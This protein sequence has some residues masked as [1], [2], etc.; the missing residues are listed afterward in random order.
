MPLGLRTTN[1]Y[2]GEPDRR[3]LVTKHGVDDAL[4]CTLTASNFTGKPG[5]TDGIVPALYPIVVDAAGKATTFVGTS[6]TPAP[7]SG[8]LV[9]AYDISNGDEPAAYIPHGTI[10]PAY[11]PVNFSFAWVSGT[12]QFIAG[13][14]D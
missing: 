7:L 6:G 10:D 5:V 12:H 8:F 11:L 14:A 13:K 2:G 1:T 9:N 4:G 3:A